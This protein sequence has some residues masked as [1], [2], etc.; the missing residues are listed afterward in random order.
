MKWSVPPPWRIQL[1]CT[2]NNNDFGQ[3]VKSAF[4]ASIYHAIRWR[5]A[6]ADAMHF[7][8]YMTSKWRIA[9]SM[10]SS[11]LAA[12]LNFIPQ[13]AVLLQCRKSV[14]LALK[15]LKTHTNDACPCY[16]TV[17]RPISDPLTVL[18]ARSD[19]TLSM[20][21]RGYQNHTLK[22][23][24]LGKWLLKQ[25]TQSAQSFWQWLVSC[26]GGRVNFSLILNCPRSSTMMSLEQCTWHR[27]F[28]LHSKCRQYVK[29]ELPRWLSQQRSVKHGT[30]VDPYG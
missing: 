21:C 27:R 15:T 17:L 20:I 19:S 4:L 5:S 13:C 22:R 7:Y 10:N 1:A 30:V 11:P 25:W 23:M 16:G 24:N 14:P 9:T 26:Q 29:D 12:V 3:G 2:P 8:G 28:D 18:F 6:R